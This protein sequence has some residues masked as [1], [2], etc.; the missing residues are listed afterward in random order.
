[1]IGSNLDTD[2]LVIGAGPVGLTISSILHHNGL[3][4]MLVDKYRV[5]P[6]TPRGI[7]I[8]QATLD[9]FKM[10]GL[11]K[12]LSTGL[13][14]DHV[15]LYWKTKKIGEF[16]FHNTPVERP[17][18]FHIM[19]NEVESNL[20]AN[21]ENKGLKINK[22]LELINYSQKAETIY[23]VMKSE[24]NKFQISSK[25]LIG[26][27]GG[28]SKVREIMGGTIHQRFYGPSFIIADVKLNSQQK[29]NTQYIFTPSGY[30]MIVPAPGNIYRLIFSIK[31]Q[32]LI[33]KSAD[34]IQ[35]KTFI[36]QLL[37]SRISKNLQITEIIWVTHAQYGHRI[38]E[39]IYQNRVVLAGDSMHQFSPVGGTN[40]N[41]GI[42]DA[43]LLAWRIVHMHKDSSSL[44]DEYA[45]ERKTLI[46]KQ[47]YSTEWVTALITRSKK[48]PDELGFN[49]NRN[50]KKLEKQ[51]TGFY[52]GEHS[53]HLQYY[54]N[55][56]EHKNIIKAAHEH[57]LNTQFVLLT[58]GNLSNELRKSIE[59]FLLHKQK[60]QWINSASN[61]PLIFFYCR[62]D[63]VVTHSGSSEELHLLCN[64]TS[65]EINAP[66]I[67]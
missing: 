4:V 11:E 56:K 26:C 67:K 44:L 23:S 33:E 10:L 38:S 65:G 21:L 24:N 61:A 12:I 40:M 17:Y 22:G 57:F 34:E 59:L 30:V 62:P 25:F 16:N 50:I 7:A 39:N 41:I 31:D 32:S 28:H 51:L 20:E 5:R 43:Y 46:N 18:F 64:L 29:P 13:K 49:K 9:I 54:I 58:M 47:Q 8:N 6:T 66:K 1:M 52:S 55:Y 63:S 35:S 2:V 42:Q 37:Y 53:H 19:Q 14:I 48:Y 45:T 3:R 15:D 27:D 60:V 36:E